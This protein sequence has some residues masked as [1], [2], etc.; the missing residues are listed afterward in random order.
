MQLPSLA[1]IEVTQRCHPIIPICQ[2]ACRGNCE[3]DACRHAFALVPRW[4]HKLVRTHMICS[5]ACGFQTMTCLQADQQGLQGLQ[6]YVMCLQT[7]G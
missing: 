6:T 1:N 4:V 5:P 2:C 7:C 3:L